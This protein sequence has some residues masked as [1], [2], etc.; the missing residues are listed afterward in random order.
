MTED[1]IEPVWLR[2]ERIVTQLMLQYVRTE[3]WKERIDD[4]GYDETDADA[5]IGYF[6]TIADTIISE[7]S[8]PFESTAQE[9]ADPLSL[10]LFDD[11][12]RG[13]PFAKVR[14][15]VK[16][17]RE[18]DEERRSG[19]VSE[20]AFAILKSAIHHAGNALAEEWKDAK[21]GPSNCALCRI[22]RKRNCDDYGFCRGCPVAEKTGLPG[23]NGT[24]YID[25]VKAHH[26]WMDAGT[27][28]E[29]AFARKAFREAEVQE[30][31]FLLRLL[32]DQ[33]KKEAKA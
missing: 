25:L 31:L 29:A 9:M 2:K 22:F 30:V 16:R 1:Q 12:G 4:N 8:P 18:A 23:C 15:A 20:T 10:G 5:I 32:E 33:F 13:A 19:A 7:A 11:N 14:E 17:L 26:E 21:L 28:E 3:T 27:G 24:P 6:C